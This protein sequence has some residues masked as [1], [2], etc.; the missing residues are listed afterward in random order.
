VHTTAVTPPTRP[1]VRALTP[2]TA[3]TRPST[4]TTLNGASGAAFLSAPLT[5]PTSRRPARRAFQLEQR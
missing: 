3:S 1:R 4:G 2:P 5:V